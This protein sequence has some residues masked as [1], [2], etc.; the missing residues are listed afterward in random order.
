MWNPV[1]EEPG[2]LTK[3]KVIVVFP[4]SILRY[5]LYGATKMSYKKVKNDDTMWLHFLHHH[6]KSEMHDIKKISLTKKEV[7]CKFGLHSQT[8]CKIYN[9]GNIFIQFEMALMLMLILTYLFLRFT[10]LWLRYGVL[11]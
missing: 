5:G 11:R 10:S 9:F 4:S 2:I 8:I 3:S 1:H 7:L 6:Q